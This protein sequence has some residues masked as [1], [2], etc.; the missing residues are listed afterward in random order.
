M[1]CLICVMQF[2]FLKKLNKIVHSLSENESET[3]RETLLRGELLGGSKG[4]VYKVFLWFLLKMNVLTSITN[5][6]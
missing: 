5:M 4:K 1:Y 2:F 3:L 6:H